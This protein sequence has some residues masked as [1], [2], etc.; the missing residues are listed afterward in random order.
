MNLIF[1][2]ILPVVTTLL[3]FSFIKDHM[4]DECKDND[5]YKRMTEVTQVI[6]VLVSVSSM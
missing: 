2:I 3:C 6:I 5:R 1:G 4:R